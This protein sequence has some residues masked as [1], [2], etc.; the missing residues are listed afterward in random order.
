MKYV[1][2]SCDV[3]NRLITHRQL[4][5]NNKHHSPHLQ[6]AYNKYNKDNFT[7]DII[8]EVPIENLLEEEQKWLDIAKQ[9]PDKWYNTSFNAERTR[10]GMKH[11]D[12]TKKKLSIAHK[13][14]PSWNKGIPMAEETKKKLSLACIGKSMP[15]CSEETKQKISIANTGKLQSE[16]VKQ[17][18]SILLR[19]KPTW[20]STHKKEM[21]EKMS[22]NK[23][24]LSDKTIY[25][26]INS[27]TDESFTGNRYDFYTKYNLDKR[28]IHAVIRGQRQSHKG[29]TLCR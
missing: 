9:E 13:G 23:N 2:S 18:R 4:L 6:N 24:P 27:R 29:W 8:K 15:S 5:K 7:F 11:S 10:A 28:N 26:F 1:G 22:G 3:K 25:S 14:M 12:E 19:G 17:K 16:E 20:S 21:S